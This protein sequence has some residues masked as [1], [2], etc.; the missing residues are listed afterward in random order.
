M[1]TSLAVSYKHNIT[2]TVQLRVHVVVVSASLLSADK[3]VGALGSEVTWYFR[4]T[5]CR[6]PNH[7]YSE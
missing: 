6:T 3:Q 7:R 1:I 2:Q 4:I 5:L